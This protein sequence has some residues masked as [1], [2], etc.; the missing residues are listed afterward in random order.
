MAGIKETKEMISLVGFI[1][2]HICK[3]IKKDGFQY[4]D[5]VSYLK[6]DEFD[7][8]L[9]PAV[10]GALMIPAEV[11]D[12]GFFEGVELSRHIYDV[13]VEEILKVLKESK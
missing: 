11:T 10:D 1:A 4:T 7:A 2:V 8:V 13:V 6:S 12:I 3:E 9:K 5:L